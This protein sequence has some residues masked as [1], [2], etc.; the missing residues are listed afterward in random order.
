MASLI[1]KPN[2]YMARIRVYSHEKGEF[3]WTARQTWTH[4]EQKAQQIAAEMQKAANESYG[5]GNSQ[6]TRHRAVA[7]VEHILEISGVSQ[8]CRPTPRKWMDAFE[9]YMGTRDLAENTKKSYHSKVNIFMKWLGEQASVEDVTPDKVKGFKEFL[10]AGWKGQ[11]PKAILNVV[12]RVQEH[13]RNLGWVDHNPVKTVSMSNKVI[14]EREPFTD[15][16]IGRLKQVAD[17]EWLTLIM[18][19]AHTGQRLGD[20]LNM[21]SAHFNWGEG[22]ITVTQQKTGSKL[23]IPVVEPLLTYLRTFH[24]E[25]PGGLYCPKLNNLGV[26]SVSKDFRHIVDRALID[27]NEVDGRRSKT[28]HSFRTTMATRLMEKGVDKRVAMAIT[29]H[30]DEATHDDYSKV[31]I[32]Q[33]REA[34]A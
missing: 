23:T 14:V 11:S 33:M 5:D 9:N 4:D 2:G 17:G 34:L 20:C 30:R 8:D 13:A 18:L 10:Q 12:S 19:A 1:S 22:T 15:A 26:K 31:S 21:R 29:G 6:M 28:F 16:E 27:Y 25:E 32:E 24:T 7:I 3:I